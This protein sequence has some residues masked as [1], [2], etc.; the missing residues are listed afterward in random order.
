MTVEKHVYKDIK[1]FCYN[2]SASVVLIS[3]RVA[4]DF[5]LSA[6]LSKHDNITISIFIV[7]PDQV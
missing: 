7:P 5:I 3:T 4:F 2:D 1:I 6:S